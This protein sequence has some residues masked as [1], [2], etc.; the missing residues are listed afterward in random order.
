MYLST[1]VKYNFHLIFVHYSKKFPAVV[2]M[3]YCLIYSVPSK[4]RM[5]YCLV[6]SAATEDRTN[7]KN[8]LLFTLLYK[9]VS[10]IFLIAESTTV[11]NVR[12]ST[13][14]SLVKS[15]GYLRGKIC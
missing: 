12:I 13:K 7:E 15:N 10:Y 8:I 4:D 1:D 14:R 3:P 6:Y 2:A 9:Y 11:E 5:L